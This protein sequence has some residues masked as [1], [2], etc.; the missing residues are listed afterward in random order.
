MSENT[1]TTEQTNVIPLPTQE[2][3]TAE[4]NQFPVSDAQEIPAVEQTSEQ[5][6]VAEAISGIDL[7]KLTKDDVFTDIINQAKLFAFRLMVGAALLEQLIIK[8]HNESNQ[9]ENTE[10]NTSSIEST[11]QSVS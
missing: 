3:S 4:Q 5:D 7:N 11:D 10:D 6:P 8:G 9:K 1:N 2:S